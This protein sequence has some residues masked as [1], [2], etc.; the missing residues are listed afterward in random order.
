MSKKNE[1]L[2]AIRVAIATVGFLAL[3]IAGLMV[4]GYIISVLVDTTST[5]ASEIKTENECRKKGYAWHAV[6]GCFTQ[7]MFIN[8]FVD[9]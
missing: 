3:F 2:E 4:V 8:N 5:H 6:D 9:R 7:E 1:I